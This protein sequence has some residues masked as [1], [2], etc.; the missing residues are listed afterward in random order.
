MTRVF[1]EPSGSLNV[2]L[3]R[4][5]TEPRRSALRSSFLN[6]RLPMLNVTSA[7]PE[8]GSVPVFDVL[9][10]LALERQHRGAGLIAAEPRFDRLVERLRRHADQPGRRSPRLVGRIDRV[11][12]GSVDHRQLVVDDVDGRD[13]RRCAEVEAGARRAHPHLQRLVALVGAVLGRLDRERLTRDARRERKRPHRRRV[14]VRRRGIARSDLGRVVDGRRLV[15]QAGAGQRH[16]RRVTLAYRGHRVVEPEHRDRHERDRRDERAGC[17]ANPVVVR[18][19]RGRRAGRRVDPHET[20]ERVARRLQRRVVD[21]RLRLDVVTGNAGDVT[22]SERSDL[23]DHAE[24]RRAL[25]GTAVDAALTDELV[26]IRVDAEQRRRRSGV[27]V[28]VVGGGDDRALAQVGVGG[29]ERAVI[30]PEP[31]V[32]V[33]QLPTARR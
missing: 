25:G 26:L 28:L 14:V 5:F 17:S 20:G 11:R 33:G 15:Q 31:E 1:V 29:D 19:R 30:R 9:G 4:R 21:V 16:H 13:E 2:P 23:G 8:S 3:I 12:G 7:A 6:S 18:R 24:V 27:D 22:R 10:A 32:V